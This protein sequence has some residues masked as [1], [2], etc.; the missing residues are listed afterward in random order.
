VRIIEATVSGLVVA[1]DR[2]EG[3]R[4][5]DGNVL[6]ASAVVVAPR[7]VARADLLAPL[8]IEPVEA[9]RGAGTMIEA[10][11]V[12]AT[13]APGL[14]VAGNVSNV[15]ANVLGAAAAGA[16]VATTINA[17]LVAED[18]ERAQ[19]PV[20]DEAFWEERYRSKPQVWSGRPN[21]HL[22]SEAERLA[23]GAALDVGAGEGADAIWLAE[24]GWE[25]TA[26]DLSTVALDRGQRRAEEVGVASRITWLQADVTAWTPPAGA[27]DLV[28]AHYLHPDADDRDIVYS[29]IATAVAPGGTLLLVGHHPTDMD[30]GVGRPRW[31]E[32]YVTADE[33]AAGLGAGWT[34]VAADARSREVTGPD[35]AP[36]TVHDAVLVARR[37]EVTWVSAV[38]ERGRRAREVR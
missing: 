14:F 5:D 2:L 24:R 15:A 11:A 21:P 36:A 26:V 9:P 13:A 33:L 27:Y 28:S 30:S 35:G 6:P 3:V 17:D 29:A 19:R 32:M 12:G 22:V 38:A 10:D 34:V 1:D 7:M 20:M 31:P 25:V 4:L 16:L 37:E 18:T 8:G 23:P